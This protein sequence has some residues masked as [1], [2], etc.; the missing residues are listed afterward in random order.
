[1]QK[2]QSVKSRHAADPLFFQGLLKL[3]LT[4]HAIYCHIFKSV[5]HTATMADRGRRPLR[6]GALTPPPPAKARDDSRGRSRSKSRNRSLSRD[7]SRSRD[8]SPFGKFGSGF[9]TMIKN[10]SPIVEDEEVDIE[11]GPILPQFSPS[12]EHQLDS[13][14]IDAIWVPQ[15]SNAQ[16]IEEDFKKQFAKDTLLRSMPLKRKEVKKPATV[17]R[18]ESST[19]CST[20]SGFEEDD[21]G[22]EPALQEDHE[23]NNDFVNLHDSLR[24]KSTNKSD[25]HSKSILEDAIEDIDSDMDKSKPSGIFG[26]IQRRKPVNLSLGHAINN[27]KGTQIPEDIENKPA[28]KHT[29]KN[30]INITN[31]LLSGKPIDSKFYRNGNYDEILEDMGGFRFKSRSK[32]KQ[33]AQNLKSKQLNEGSS[34]DTVNDKFQ[35]EFQD[36]PSKNEGVTSNLMKLYHQIP[37]SSADDIFSEFSDT[38]SRNSD[39]VL[40]KFRMNERMRKFRN[41]NVF[42]S[43]RENSREPRGNSS[44]DIDQIKLPDFTIPKVDKKIKK[45]KRKSKR[46]RAARITV[47]IV[48][49]VHRQEFLLTLCKAFMLF[50]APNHRLEEYMALASKV[51]EVEATFIYLPGMMLVNFSDPVTRTSDLKLVR[52]GQGL[53]LDKLD[54]SHDIYE[55]VVYD[56]MGVDEASEI[57]NGLFISKDYFNVYWL[58]LLY[59]LSSTFVICFFNGSWLDMIPIFILGSLLG[60]FQC[61]IAPKNAIYSSVFEVGSAIVISFVG[62]AVGSIAGGKYFCFSAIVLSGLCMILPGYMIL[63]GALEIQS[64][65]IVSGVVGMFYAIIY[66]LFLGFGLTLGSALYGWLDKNAYDQTTCSNMGHIG[67]IWKLLFVPLFNI[68]LSLASQA[69]WNQVSIMTII[70]CCGYLVTY[71]SSLHFSLAQFNSALG[72]FTVGVLS[73]VYDRWGKRYKRFGHCSTKFTSMIT[74]IFD[75]VPG[76]FAARNVLSGG[77]TQLSSSKNDTASTTSTTSSNTL[78][79]GISMIEIAIGITVGLF[80]STLAVYPFGKRRSEGMSIGL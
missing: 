46:E 79:F 64:R 20:D 75:L 15:Q 33:E 10:D 65:S 62:R 74:G 61:V 80:V 3:Q 67:D 69:R 16:E 4:P 36:S 34:N 14:D 21:E 68:F 70:G 43:S 71:F 11:L 47:H 27:T 12:G 9:P 72:A 45:I 49:L 28:G 41:S 39:T 55:A 6:F 35:R 51:L 19:D 40:S 48:D 30:I 63:R 32:R 44:S 13:A 7:R 50:G 54:R 8:R 77:L 52:V 59:G 56:S 18:A 73:N 24:R 31:N 5:V 22:E 60:F 2:N 58:I 17:L 25:T 26:W 76:G 53:N 29:S 1:M 42:G 38:A 57:L 78:T 37:D 66:S 23:Q